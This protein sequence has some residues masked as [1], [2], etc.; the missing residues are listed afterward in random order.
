VRVDAV[1]AYSFS[2]DGRPLELQFN[3]DNLFDR[4][5]VAGSHVHISRYILPGEGRN[6]SVSLSYRF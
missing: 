4:T 1:Q 3:I 6:G 5:Y 2:L